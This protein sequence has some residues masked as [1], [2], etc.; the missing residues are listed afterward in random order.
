MLRPRFS[1]RVLFL[2]TALIAVGC[3]WLILPTVR[4]RQFIN[5]VKSRD[6]KLADSYFSNPQEKFFVEL[7][8]EYPTFKSTAELQTQSMRQLWNGEQSVMGGVSIVRYQG[9]VTRF[10]VTRTG[11]YAENPEQK[12]FVQRFFHRNPQ[13]DGQ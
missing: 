1:L 9:Y 3:L 2:A 4:A 6:F 7:A 12:D 5:A 13:H 8:A 10:V 11:L